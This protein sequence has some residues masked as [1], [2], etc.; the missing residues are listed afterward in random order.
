MTKPAARKEAAVAAEIEF[1]IGA[2]ASC[3]DGHC[4]EVKRLVF[5]P[6]TEK[7]THLV[8]QH[9][10]RPEAARLVPAHLAETT[11]GEIRLR[12]T[13]AEFAKFDHAEERE[14]ADAADQHLGDAGALGSGLAYNVSG[15]AFARVGGPGELIDIGPMPPP[16]HRRTMI[17]DVVPLGEDQVRPGE[18][19]H[20]VD[21]EI[22]RVQGFLVNPGDDRVTHV[23]LQEGHLWG[24]KEVAIP[25]TAVTK[26]DIGIRLN[27]TKDQVGNLPPAD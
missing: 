16:R 19:V 3:S 7:V 6:A 1:T 14:A 22:G 24:R 4:G 25:I 5:D 27:L 26:V 8:I 23:L 17:E 10:H 2:R 12:C 21:G 20:A 18:P 13:L 11:D 9:G 15:E